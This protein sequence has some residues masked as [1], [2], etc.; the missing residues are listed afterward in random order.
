MLSSQED[1]HD[2]REVQR[3]DLSVRQQQ[4]QGS[5]YLAQ[6]HNDTGG[7]FSAV[8]AATVI[9]AKPDVASAYPAASSAHQ[10]QLPNEPPIDEPLELRPEVQGN[11]GDA[12]V[13]SSGTP[14]ADGPASPSSSGDPAGVH[15]PSPPGTSSSDVNAGS[16][17]FR[18]LR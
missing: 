18:R 7:R 15:F 4:E 1:Q 9:G 3:N 16:L 8:G 10:I 14:L 11:S 5:T 6:T 17:P 13:P 2:R 12:D